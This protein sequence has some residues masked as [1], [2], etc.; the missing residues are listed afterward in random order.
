MKNIKVQFFLFILLFLAGFTEL[1]GQFDPAR[2]QVRFGYNVHNTYARDFNHLIDVFNNERYPLEIR[3]NLAPINFLHGI[4]FG[5]RY[6]I[7]DGIFLEGIFK[8]KHQF[9]QSQYV[10]PARYRKFLFRSNTV[11]FGVSYEIMEEKWF[12]HAAGAGILIGDLAV[13]TAWDANPGNQGT[14]KMLNIDQSAAIGISFSYEA[15]FKLAEFVQL[16]IRPVMQFSLNS[17]VRN[18]NDFMNPI[19]GG[20]GKI[21]YQ[22]IEDDKYNSGTLNGVGMEGGLIVRLPQ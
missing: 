20:D 18:L 15:Q 9:L 6:E 8:N 14:G 16:Y 19:I 3:N 4:S 2:L 11:E 17:H 13:Y 1:M 7:A 10:D 5:G 12:T 21:T 22:A